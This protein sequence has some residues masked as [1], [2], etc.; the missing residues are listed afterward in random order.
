MLASKLCSSGANVILTRNMDTFVSLKKRVSI[1]HQY[2]ADAFISVHYDASIDSSISGFTTYY[3]N[4]FQ[5]ELAVAV[6]DGLKSTI[7]LRNRGAQPSNYFVLRENRQNAILLELG[8]L[9]NASE[10]SN[11][12]YR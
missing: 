5:K 9:S 6:N 1:S 11:V 2:D 3:T 8:F 12:Q 7:S 4:G 10:E